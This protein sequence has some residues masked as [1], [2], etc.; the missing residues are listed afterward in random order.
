MTLNCYD[1]ILPSLPEAVRLIQMSIDGDLARYRS[2]SLANT[3]QK[4][5]SSQRKAYLSFCQAL[6]YTA[7]PASTTTLCRY[8][9]FLARTH[10][11]T[12]IKQYFNIIRQLHLEWDLPNPIADNYHL[13]YT[14]RGIKRALGEKVSR[15]LPITPDILISW[16]SCLDLKQPLHINFWAASLLMFYAMLRRSNVLPVSFATFDPARHLRRK[17][18][19]FHKNGCAIVIRWSKTIQFK[20]RTLVIPLPRIHDSNLCPV[21]ALFRTFSMTPNASQEGPA[22][23][24]TTKQPLRLQDFL[25]VLKTVVQQSGLDP[26]A[27]SGHSFRRGGASWAFQ[28]G[29]SIETIRQIGDWKSN[30]Y[31]KYI[32]ESA[33]TLQKTFKLISSKLPTPY[34]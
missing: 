2:M 7:I 24:V 23:M 30:A 13:S 20:E 10:K 6:G 14:L 31:T 3:S 5:Y 12:S 21:Q 28:C 16:L 29:V 1:L 34:N 9:A 27:Y 25:K 33:E 17:D 19:I 11:F 32:F 26:K 18:V 4:T 15:K 8:A 22:L